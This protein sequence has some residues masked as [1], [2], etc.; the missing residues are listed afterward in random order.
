MKKTPP[1]LFA[2]PLIVSLLLC[3][4]SLPAETSVDLAAAE[5]QVRKTDANW[6]AAASAANADAWLG[7]YA[8]DAIVLLPAGHPASGSG[9]IRDAVGRFLSQPR[10]SVAWHPAQLDMGRSGELALVSGTYEL[11]F[12]DSLGA[13]VSDRGRRLEIWRKLADGTWKCSVDTWNSDGPGAAPTASAQ[14]HSP[15]AVSAA[16]PAPTV[17][18][19]PTPAPTT[20]K[21]YG[22][23]PAAYQDAIRNYYLEHLKNPDS[24][25]YREITKPEQGYI[26]AITGTLLMSET[27]E[28]GWTVKATINATN[29]NDSYVGFKTYTFLFRGE[30]I[31]DLRLPL[32]GDEMK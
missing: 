5:A 18:S 9:L 19:P 16:P 7:F 17:P 12:G 8:G 28:Y 10:F 14:A 25:Q 30:K 2:A 31:V 27:R 23:M 29:S 20:D 22:A 1:A 15:S 24:V 21:K 3:R 13:L 6:T 4:P 32:P 26:T 11:R